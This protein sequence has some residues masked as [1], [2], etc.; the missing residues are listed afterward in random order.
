VWH[1]QSLNNCA[2]IDA[3]KALFDGPA[4]YTAAVDFPASMCWEALAKAYPDAKVVHTQRASA[5]E[6]YESASNSIFVLT[7]TF[8][9]NVVTVVVPFFKR[10]AAMID[11]L[12]SSMVGHPVSVADAGWPGVYKAELMAAYDA[13]TARVKSGVPLAKLHVQDHKKGWAGLCTFLKKPVPDA[14]YPHVNSRAEFRA[15]FLYMVVGG[16]VAAVMAF[17][18]LFY[19]CRYALRLLGEKRKAS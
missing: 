8:P 2:D 4:G 12:F 1:E 9:F 19:A 3:I 14:P 6:W 16:T 18:A 10:H 5:E 15:M 11:G 7:T 13:N 17:A